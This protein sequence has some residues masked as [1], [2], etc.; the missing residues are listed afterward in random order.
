MQKIAPNVYIETAYPPI[1]IG[2]VLTGSGWVIID[3]PAMPKDAQSF[4]AELKSIS[5]KPAIYV[6]NTDYHR[7]R[8]LGNSWFEAP[9]VAQSLT[10]FRMLDLKDTFVSTAADELSSNDNELVAIAS[11]SLIP[12]QVSF[13]DA[14]S[15]AVEDREISLIHRVGS[16]AGISW[17]I[18]APEKIVFAGDSVVNHQ[19]PVILEGESKGWLATLSELRRGRYKD[20]T[21]VPGRGE[22]ISSK[23]TE[24]LSEYLRIARRRISSL[25]RAGL[26]RPEINAIVPD[27]LEMFPYEQKTR[28]IIQRRVKSGLEA[29]YD[30]MRGLEDENA[31]AETEEAE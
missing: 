17:V 3:T 4:L 16:S 15:L 25:H 8:I 1:T 30:E 6:V 12:P 24:P 7:D 23:D 29:I 20:W 21:L 19:H 2:A 9:V 13:T 5:K 18:L 27:F 11:L 22:P 26:P 14:L 31:E 10:A 28:E